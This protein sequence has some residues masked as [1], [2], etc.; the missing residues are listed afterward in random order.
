MADGLLAMADL[1]LPVEPDG[2]AY[3]PNARKDSG[4]H[5]HGGSDFVGHVAV[6]GSLKSHHPWSWAQQPAYS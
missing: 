3:V 1:V 6:A 4:R 5:S 2:V